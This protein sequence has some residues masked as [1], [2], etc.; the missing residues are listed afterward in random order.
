MVLH[1]YLIGW[2]NRIQALTEFLQHLA[3]FP[4][5]WNPT[6]AEC[7]DYWLRAYPPETALKLESSIWQ[8][9]EGSLS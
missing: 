2:C 8:H 3:G 5:L 7:A 1:P 6:H 4:D 9:H